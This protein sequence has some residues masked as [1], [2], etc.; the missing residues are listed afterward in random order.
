[1][2]LALLAPLLALA[3]AIAGLLA[4]RAS[5]AGRIAV[6]AL[7][8]LSGLASIAAGV[9]A[10]SG[11]APAMARLPLGLPWLE[12][13][14]RL[15]GLSG[16]FLVLLGAVLVPVSLFGPGYTRA[17][18]Q[19]PTPPAVL[20]LF[21]G[22]FVAGMQLVVLADDAFMFM[23]A[24]E[25]MS[26]ASYFLVAFEHQHAANR[27]A[28]FL[29]LLMAHVG[30]LAILLGFGV[31]SDAGGAYSFDAMRASNPG[32]GWASVAFG[33]ALAGFGMKAGLMPLHAW[34][35]QAHPA[36]PSHISALMS[37]VMLKIAVY[38]FVRFAFDLLPDP[39]WGWGVSVLIVGSVSA[40]V[41]VLFALVETDIKRM[42]AWSSV[43]NVGIIFLGL[44]F[45]LL[46]AASGAPTL[47]ALGLVA[48]LYHAINHALFKSLLFL[49]AG[50]VAHTC[51]ERDMEHLGGLIHRMPITAGCFLVGCISIAALPPF[52]GFVSEWLTFQTFLQVSL[53]D[54]GA[55]RAMLPFAAALLALT[56]AL[57]AACFVKVFGIVFLGVPRSRHARHA[58]EV[59]RGM[60]AGQGLLAV[61]CLAF[62][63]LP[64]VVVD[65]LRPVAASLVRGDLA[66][67]TAGGW[68][69]LTPVAPQVASYSAPLVLAGIA[70]AGLAISWT[71]RRQ[72]RT[73]PVRREAPW[74]C[75]FGGL[76]PRMQYTGT[77]FA[78]P[79]RRV[80]APLWQLHENVE[81][82][83]PDSVAPGERS[84]RLRHTLQI[85]DRC[86]AW[87]YLPPV[88]WIHA[89]ARQVARLQTGRIRSYLVHSFITLLVLLWVVT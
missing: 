74:D 42:L 48:A 37:G 87:L 56:G 58:H 72:R 40:L 21:S 70:L 32:L 83:T 44:G 25:I 59:D 80:F 88:R 55:L 67:A 27:R 62:G 38:G 77:A 36:A 3:S 66:H 26:L 60:L 1:M 8:G 78:M 20:H 30:A 15:D 39:H 64:F 24:W 79:V 18:A 41:G 13:R 6:F 11:D 49:G 14:L 57:A 81:A 63:V 7:L 65:A 22:L 52:N 47:A 19:G 29:Y 17:F 34:L 73:H 10:L 33:L 5:A 76:Q 61:L 51:H 28:A 16:F 43:E 84:V 82:L 53:L 54:S 50:A 75:G 69:W 23:V 31:L 86:W 68:L 4:P 45:S 89:S 46:F 85:E 71:R 35:P 12:W 9:V 2:S